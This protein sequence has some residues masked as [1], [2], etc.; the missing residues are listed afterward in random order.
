[1]NLSIYTFSKALDLSPAPHG[2][3]YIVPTSDDVS[4]IRWFRT[5][6][7]PRWPSY[8]YSDSVSNFTNFF[9]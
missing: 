6:I 5:L 4:K 7:R 1:M 8:M 2:G 3:N 9:E